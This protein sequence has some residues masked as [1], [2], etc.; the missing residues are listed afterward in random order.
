MHTH[1]FHTY[2]YITICKVRHSP[3][4]Q[5][6]A[7]HLKRLFRAFSFKSPSYSLPSPLIYGVILKDNEARWLQDSGNKQTEAE[8]RRL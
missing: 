7:N 1:T 3:A 4:F 6:N 2:M 8:G 5:M